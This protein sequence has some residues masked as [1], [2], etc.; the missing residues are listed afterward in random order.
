MCNRLKIPTVIGL[1]ITGIF[2]GPYGLQIIQS[3][4]DVEL[5]AEI[6]IITLLFTIGLELSFEEISS[7]KRAIFVGV[8]QIFIT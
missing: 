6:G 7:L 4:A 8:L 3:T 1:L 5:F 2:V